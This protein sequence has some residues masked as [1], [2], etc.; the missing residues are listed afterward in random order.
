MAVSNLYASLSGPQ[1][2]VHHKPNHILIFGRLLFFCKPKFLKC[3]I[4]FHSYVN[5]YALL[6]K[7]VQAYRKGENYYYY[8]YYYYYILDSW[9]RENFNYGC[10]L[11]IPKD[12]KQLRATMLLVLKII[13]FIVLFNFEGNLHFYTSCCSQT[14]MQNM[15]D[16]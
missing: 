14:Y 4:S 10:L 16:N 7:V 13:N 5:Q 15:Q 6:Y 12:V 9:G 2:Q 11:K 8:Y 3:A 1:L